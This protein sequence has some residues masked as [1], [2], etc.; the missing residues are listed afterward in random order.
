MAHI[1][2]LLPAEQGRD[3][4]ERLLL[5]PAIDHHRPAGPGDSLRIAV[6]EQALR[7]EIIIS[8]PPIASPNQKTLFVDAERESALV[9]HPFQHRLVIYEGPKFPFIIH[10]EQ[11]SHRFRV[12]QL[13]AK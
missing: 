1:L 5:K 2:G 9:W 11:Y 6:L 8:F 7:G 10:P 12:A 3:L 4:H 13:A